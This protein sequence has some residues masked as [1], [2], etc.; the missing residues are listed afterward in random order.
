MSGFE[1]WVR[2]PNIAGDP[3]TYELENEAIARDGRLDVALAALAP[4]SNNRLLDVGCG[5]GFWLPR[6]ATQAASVIGV[7]PDP[8]LL[9]L[10]QRRVAS[11]NNAK[12]VT[13]SAEHLPLPDDSIDVAHARFAYFFGPGAEAGLDEVSR[14]LTGEGA[15]LVVDNSWHGG[16]FAKLLRQ[17]TVGNAAVNP[18]EVEAWWAERG[19]ERHELVGGWQATSPAELRRI[20]RLEFPGDVV[21]AFL[22]DH[23]SQALSYHFNIYLWRP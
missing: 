14:V 23:N 8:N 9:A 1:D 2:S 21:D 22:R 5:A 3:E 7:E 19:A 16:D 20:L 18:I 4:L 17:S 10:A 12:A 15:L 6:Y 11:L 13:G